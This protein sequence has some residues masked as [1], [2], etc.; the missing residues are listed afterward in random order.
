MPLLSFI[1]IFNFSIAMLTSLAMLP[2]MSDTAGVPIVPNGVCFITYGSSS[3][4]INLLGL[5]LV[6]ILFQARGQ[7][8]GFTSTIAFRLWEKRKENLV[9]PK[10][11]KQLNQTYKIKENWLYGFLISKL[12]LATYVTTFT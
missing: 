5:L 1:L 9:I 8:T 6:I 7:Y 11:R 3:R 2:E 10:T 4:F 12:Q